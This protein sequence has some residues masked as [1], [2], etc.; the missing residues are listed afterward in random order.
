MKSVKAD[1]RDLD[2]LDIQ[3][4]GKALTPIPARKVLTAAEK[5][6]LKGAVSVGGLFSNSVKLLNEPIGV[7]DTKPSLSITMPS[8][9]P[10]GL[11]AK[12]LVSDV[13]LAVGMSAS[14]F[15]VLGVTGSFGLYGSSTPELGLFSSIGGGWWTNVGVSVGPQITLIFGPP[16]DLAGVSWGIGCDCK[17]MAGSIGGL[18]LFSPPPFKFL[19]ISVSLS[20][21]PSAIPA[22]D[23]TMQV[24]A[25]NILP[26]AK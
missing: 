10:V 15:A 11:A 3:K 22:F 13:T 8:K 14:A 26:I 20:V 16:S 4:Q 18:L 1:L 19:G 7:S 23:V 12:P 5:T 25:T 21:G 9:V 17:F 6:A 2:K 24:S